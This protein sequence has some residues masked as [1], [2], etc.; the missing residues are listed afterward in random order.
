M[1]AYLQGALH[2]V[3]SQVRFPLSVAGVAMLGDSSVSKRGRE[4]LRE[5]ESRDGFAVRDS[6]VHYKF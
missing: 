4:R 5:Q 6:S 3:R 1:R 2:E